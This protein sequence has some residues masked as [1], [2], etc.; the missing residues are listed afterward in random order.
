MSANTETIRDNTEEYSDLKSKASKFPHAFGAYLFR[1]SEDKVI[2]VGK[3]NDL[4]KRV[5]SY[6]RDDSLKSLGIIREARAIDY[7]TT[8]SELEALLLECNLIKRYKPK[9]NVVL[10]DDKS[11]PYIA[12]TG[13]R[14][15]RVAIT[16]KTDIRDTKYYGPYTAGSIRKTLDMMRKAFPFASCK[17]PATGSGGRACLYYHIKQCAGPC[18]NA[19]TETEYDQMIK[20][21]EL[22]LQGKHGKILKSLKNR[23][24]KYSEKQQYE[25]AASVRDRISSLQIMAQ[26]Q[27]VISAKSYN[28]DI[29]G[30]A[31]SG[32][33]WLFKVFLV[34][35][36]KLIDVK[37]FFVKGLT[38]ERGA[39]R[40]F[41]IQYYDVTSMLPSTIFT[42]KGID[43]LELI[44][45]W[46]RDKT[47]RSITLLTPKIGEKRKLV[48]M[49]V[50]NAEQSLAEHIT[51]REE[52]EKQSS[53]IISE[54]KDK[55][56]LSRAPKRIEC[57]D[58]SNVSGKHAV[59][60]MVTFIDGKPHKQFYKRFKIE[61]D[62]GGD[63]KMMEEMLRR[64][65]SVSGSKDESWTHPDLIVVD[66]GI[67]QLNTCSKVLSSIDLQHIERIS[68]AKKKEDIYMPGINTPLQLEDTSKA[69]YLLMYIRDEAHRFAV[70]YHRNVRDKKAFESLLNNIEGVGQKRRRLLLE[71]FSSL[72]EIVEG[73]TTALQYLGIP[74]K[75]AENIIK[76][77]RHNY[78]AC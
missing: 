14:F 45:E 28:A 68:L 57:F 18:I 69:R 66:G 26:S 76:A 64:R 21:I 58:V 11:Y 34:R 22:F 24:K 10:R 38:D 62:S 12:I 39:I 17:E 36:G 6:F 54:L 59:G 3:A 25:R 50:A 5:A 43:D 70:K 8:S 13:K 30:S 65:F 9:F 48:E 73:G 33:K 16:R 32:D 63:V 23:M 67:G 29:I 44:E 53:E 78:A 37:D 71:K 7:V 20:E 60:S 56:G 61:T 74:K 40:S 19:I 47:G 1:D 31:A 15:P 41:V 52:A 4:Q 27:A 46:L 51:K 75:V 2:Y 72:Q 77:L 49:A 42:N 35:D 55:L